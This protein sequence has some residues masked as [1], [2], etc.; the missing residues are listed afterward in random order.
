MRSKPRIPIFRLHF[1][2][3]FVTRFQKGAKDI[4][5]SDALGE[6]HCARQFEADF[7]KL[8]H[9]KYAVAV[10]SGTIA[11]DL[12][13][14]ALDVRGKTVLMPVNTFFAT[15]IAVMNAGATP[16][17]LDIEDESLSID[18]DLLE[19]ELKKRRKGEVGA[20]I[21]VHIGGIISRHIRHIAQICRRYG[22]PLIEDA[23]HAHCSRRF[24][25]YAGSI[26]AFGCF[27]FFPTKVMTTG[28]G[29]MVTTNS[30][31]LHRRILSLKDFG[32]ALHNADLCVLEQGTNAK[33]TEFVGL[34]GVLECERVRRRII[35]RN[36]LVKRY[37]RNLRSSGYQVVLQNDG[38]CPYYKCIVKIPLHLKRDALRKYCKNNGISLTGE[39][40][41]L[42]LH[43]QPAYRKCFRGR[44]FPIAEAFC[45]H[46]ICPPLYP[47]LTNGEVD[48]ICDILLRAERTL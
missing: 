34:M 38:A 26:G 48:Y 15:S 35:R 20:I 3:G 12:A 10:T 29:G 1:D 44:S 45:A 43:H 27:S 47:E 37:A 18:P 28:Q 42:P 19:R 4:L 22:V 9:T 32:R 33:V 17:F 13:L 40:Y 11:L 25:R 2:D 23:A 14:R 8:V 7:R 16:D 5:C 24:G 31:K 39:V 41:N 6:G 30:T 46:H 36:E 21:V